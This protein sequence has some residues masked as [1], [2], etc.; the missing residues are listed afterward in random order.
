MKIAI[1]YYATS[2]YKDYFND[3]YNSL[4]NFFPG[5]EKKVHLFTDDEENLYKTNKNIEWHHLNHYP[6][7]IVSLY[8]MWRTLQNLD[9]SCDLHFHFNSNIIFSKDVDYSKMMSVINDGKLIVARHYNYAPTENPF[10]KA[11]LYIHGGIWGGNLQIVEKMCNEHS[12][13]LDRYINGNHIIPTWHDETI[14]NQWYAYN[15]NLVEVIDFHD[16]GII[17]EKYSKRVR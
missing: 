9:T 13:L 4:E 8:K 11:L 10:N 6:W 2:V 1:Y 15:P 16:Y 5:I 17:R 12:I 14:I 3:F 7:P